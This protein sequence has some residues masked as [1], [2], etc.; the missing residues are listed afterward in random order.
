MPTLLR[1]LRSAAALAGLLAAASAVA[2]PTVFFGLDNANLSAG[3]AHPNADA[4]SASFASA[5][6]ALA[7]QDFDGLALGAVPGAFSIGAVNAAFTNLA[8]AYTQI[9][10]GVGT[11]STFPISGTQYLE[12]LSG[13]GSTYFSIA[14]D[15]P[16]RALGF[17]LTDP[18]DWIGNPSAVPG[19]TLNLFQ[20]GGTTSLDLLQGLD[21]SQVVNGNVL[22]FG[23]VDTTDAITGFSISSLA[24]I[25]DEDAIGLD[26][27]QVAVRERGAVPEP[28]PLALLAVSVLALAASW[29]RKT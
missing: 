1:P 23:V 18:S 4:A 19:L 6:G 17:Y 3:G 12:S 24:S 20:S 13:N 8:T 28:A 27:L 15:Q 16:L 9:A 21:A 29:F 25:P 14:F 11:F 10:A 22:F 26:H 2:A 7:T 5:A